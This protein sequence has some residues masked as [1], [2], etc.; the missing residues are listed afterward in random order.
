MKTKSLIIALLAV[1]LVSFQCEDQNPAETVLADCIDPEL[2]RND[3]ACLMIY[4]PVCGC[5]GKTY[6]N[7]CVAGISGVKSFTP[8]ECP[9]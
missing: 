4:D 2:I 1:L 7:S 3:M 5:D 8:G 9:K 6:G